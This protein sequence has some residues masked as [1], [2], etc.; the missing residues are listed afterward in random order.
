MLSKNFASV[1]DIA[2][3]KYLYNVRQEHDA[4]G[5]GFV[6]SIDGIKSHKIVQLAVEGVINLTHRGAVSADS[7]SGDGAGIT[8]QI[9][10]ELLASEFPNF[11]DDIREGNLGIA[12]CFMPSDEKN[13]NQ[14][15]SILE[16]AITNTGLELL[17]WRSVPIDK[18]VLGGTALESLPNIIQLLI[19][20]TKDI[21]IGSEFDRSLYL[22][23]KRAEKLFRDDNLDSY[24]VSMSSRT[25]IYKGLMVANQLQAFYPDLS[26]EKTKTATALLHQRFATNTLPNWKLAQPFRI[27]AHNGEFN[28][29]LGNRNWMKAREPSLTSA[30]WKQNIDELKPVILP[31]GSDTASFDEALELLSYSGR[32]LL[33]S[34]MML[35]PEAWENM[36]NLDPNLH[37]FYEYNA[38]LTE[39]WDGPAAVVATNGSI[40]AA[41][42]DRNGL[43]PARYQITSDGL[44][45]IAS[46]VGLIDIDLNTVVESGR[47]GPGEMIAV[48]NVRKKFLNNNEIKKEIAERKPYKNWID[49]NLIHLSEKSISTDYADN[50][51]HKTL[52]IDQLEILYGYSHEEVE[53]I[54]KPMAVTAKEPVGSMGDD[55]PLSILQD[56]PRQLYSYFKQKFAQVTNPAIDSIREEVVMSLDTYLGER[57]SL[58]ESNPDAVKLIHLTSP[59][60]TNEEINNLRDFKHESFKIVTLRSVISKNINANNLIKS[61]EKLC[62]SAYQAVNDGSSIIII[63]DRIQ[64]NDESPIPMILSIAAVHHYLI[65]KNVRMKASI[66]AEAGDARDVHH[67][68][69]LIG[70]GASA[71]N[72]YLVFDILRSLVKNNEFDKLSEKEV[73]RNYNQ[74]VD[75]GI[76][77]IMSKMGI[78]TIAAYHGA[79]IFDIIGISENVTRK[80]FGGTAVSNIGGIDFEQIADDIK[81]KFLNAFNDEIK[82]KHGGWYKYRKDGDYHTYNPQVWRALQRAAQ[83]GYE[84]YQDFI[85]LAY[86][87]P[88]TKLR[89]LLSFENNQES[90][91]IDEVEPISEIVKR[92][93]TGAM[94]LGALSPET[95]EDLA[96]GMNMLGGRSNTGEGG[97][98]PERYLPGG[99]KRDANSQVKQIASGRFG[100]T[101]SYLVAANELEIKISQGSKPG[102][103]GQLPGHKVDQYIAELRH[104]MPGTPLISPPPH[105]DIYSIEDISQLIYDLKMINPDSKICVK[106]VSAE[107]VGTIAAGVAKAYADVIQI[108][109]ADGGTGASPLSSIKYAG[110]P[111]E[112]GLAETQQVLVM[113]DLRG[114][115]T[116]R[117][118]GGMHTG[119]DVVVAALLGAD[120][121]GFG[122]SALIALG[123]KMA[124]QCHLNTCPVGIATQRKDLRDKYVGTPQMLVN[125]LNYVATEVREILAS[126]GHKS[127]NEIIGRADLLKQVNAD[128][129]RRYSNVDLSKM[130]VAVDPSNTRAHSVVLDRNERPKHYIIDDE[131]LSSISKNIDQSEKFTGEYPIKNTDRTTGARIS[132]YIAKKY[133]D[134][135]LPYGTIDLTFNGS[136]GQSFGAFLSIGMRLTLIGQANDYVA[137]SM[138]GGEIVIRSASNDDSHSAVL[139]GNTLMYGATGGNLFIR[140]KVGERFAVRNSGGRAVVEGIGDHG[141]EYMTDGVIVILGNTGRNFG[142]GMSNGMAF[143]LDEKGDFRTRVNEELVGLEQISNHD[144]E[145]LLQEL[146]QRHAD[147]TDS[148]IA[149]NI[150]SDWNLYLPKFWKVAPKFAATEDGA[151]IIARKHLKKLKRMQP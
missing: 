34:L 55:T 56:D 126:L 87:R 43:R 130:I 85:R 53:Y 122:T 15:K 140:G 16:K 119:K 132:G 72:P 30:V 4:C 125:Y 10:F 35:I 12:M 77:K 131:I 73:I 25:V 36:P 151:Q 144:D 136:A 31:I 22:A 149:K 8:I 91:N 69:T 148:T 109:G 1:K 48:D 17:T 20:K 49:K 14:S 142:A 124:R 63:S 57:K 51:E 37:A 44:V 3:G 29:L 50:L 47:L 52:P 84:E 106:L 115:V 92:F 82:L 18:S 24:I 41:I 80:F 111:F 40:T 9:P 11:I 147:F 58:L 60:L 23:R 33:H 54:L 19:K 76:L 95:H 114:R 112:L 97:E 13:F 42:M 120:Q 113:N 6:A 104:V 7:T 46:E 66:I 81:L 99:T 107:G 102:E 64:T 105:H 143:V 127:I 94:S 100:V 45:I 61:I 26:N 139:A 146:I 89:D 150:L 70:F 138:R 62:D 135:G 27:V 117:T 32:S 2:D 83:N 134:E 78:S 101:P 75:T 116:L 103:G 118:D 74:A 98:D 123:C 90:I 145:Q 141:C 79:Q 96:R 93:Q 108:S 21:N 128:E 67:F 59:L 68:S 28:T 137:K 38:C 5:M 88:P 110:S 121:Y 133:G 65:E 86:D 39:P 71:V 129:G